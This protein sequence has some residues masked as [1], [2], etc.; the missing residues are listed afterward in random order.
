[1]ARVLLISA[2]TTTNPMAVY[3]LG[4]ALVDAA[5]VRQGHRT[6]QFD[7]LFDREKGQTGL[8]SAIAGFMPDI[9]G[10]SVRNIDNVDSISVHEHWYLGRIKELV[11]RI[12]KTCRVSVVLGGP[13][14]SIMPG[15]I[16]DYTGADHCIVGEGELAFNLLIEEIIKG[17]NPPAITGPLS[18]RMASWEFLAPRYKKELTEYYF[19]LSGMLNYQTKRGC[20][21]GCNYCSYPLIEGKKFRYQNPEFV[22]ENLKRLKTDFQIDSLFFTDSVFNDPAGRFLQVAEAMARAG[23]GIKWAAYFRPDQISQND[24]ALLKRSG[25]YAMEIGSDAA[26]DQTLKGIGKTFG[27]DR[28]MEFNEAAV[29]ADISCAHFFMFGGPGETPDTID[30]GLSNIKRL[31]HTVVSVFSGIRIIPGT[32]LA[33]IALSQGIISPEDDLIQPKFYIAPG[34]DKGKMNSKIEKSFSRRKDRFFP[35]ENGVIRMKAIK[36]FGFKGLLWDMM[37]KTSSGKKRKQK[38]IVHDNI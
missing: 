29:T 12:R 35:P 17:G 20:P 21:F 36:A 32:V 26:C 28:V 15:A 16:L 23:L 14:V 2:N 11:S 13:A 4:L 24:L 7:L 8:E 25:L 27:F 30:Q 5:L 37:L 3:P 33:D 6:E 18:P 31:R 34:I 10:I 22:V 1:M 38:N 9:V 19:D